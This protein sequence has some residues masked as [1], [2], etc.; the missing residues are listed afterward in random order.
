MQDIIRA[1]PTMLLRLNRNNSIP[2]SAKMGVWAQNGA[3]ITCVVNPLKTLGLGFRCF[4]IIPKNMNK[5]KLGVNLCLSFMLTLC[6]G[7]EI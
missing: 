4:M 1:W 2:G 6:S 5:V 7:L 3:H